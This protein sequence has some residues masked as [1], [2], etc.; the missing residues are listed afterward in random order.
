MAWSKKGTPAIVTVPTTK[1]NATSI[2]VAILAIFLINVSLRVP[3][4]IKKRKFGL[5]ANGCSVTLDEMDKCT[6]L[7]GYYLVMDS[8]PIHSSAD[9]EKY[10]HSS[11]I[12]I[13]LYSSQFWSVVES[14]A[15]KNKF[16]EKETLMTRISEAC[17]SL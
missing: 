15:K 13:C 11:R 17:D 9:I 16:L 10:I 8:A 1:A 6:E 7:K 14:K 5:A 2:L 12:S 4:R 3:K